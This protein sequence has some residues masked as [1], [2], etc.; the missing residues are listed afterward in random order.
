MAST[1]DSLAQGLKN[2]GGEEGVELNVSLDKKTMN[3][4]TAL[5]LISVGLGV[6]LVFLIKPK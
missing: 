2:I 6:G 1:L 3:H 5:F 4:F